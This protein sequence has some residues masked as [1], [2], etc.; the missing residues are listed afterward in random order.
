MK[1]LNIV[2]VAGTKGKGSTCAYVDSIL[3]QYRKSRGLPL[4]VGLFTSP[5]LIA[6]RERIRINS[7]PISRDLFAR[8][9][10]QVWD[11]LET[12]TTGSSA[13]PDKPVYFRYLTLLSYHVFLQEGV[14]AAIYETGVGGEYDS[15]NIVD[16]PVATGISALGIDHTF[17][18]GATV[19]KIAWHKAGIQ[20]QGVPSFTVN[21]PQ[22]AMDVV[23]ARAKERNVRSL[24]VVG[25]DPRLR[26]V[27][28]KPDADFQKANASLAIALAEVVIQNLD[29][30]FEVSGDVL[31]SEFVDGVEQVVWRGRCETK[32]EG[33]IVWYLDGAHTADSIHVASSW[34]WDECSKRQVFKSGWGSLADPQSPGNHV[35][36]FNQ[37]GQREAMGL[38]NGLFNPGSTPNPVHFDH[39]LFCPTTARTDI[40]AKKGMIS[41]TLPLLIMP[42]CLPRSADFVNHTYDHKAIAD[43]TLQK[44][45]AE[46]WRALDPSPNTKIEVLPT[47]EDAFDYVRRLD[48]GSQAEGNSKVHALITG[49]VHLV[50]R[51]LGALEGVDA[52]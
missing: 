23:S 38:L 50:G 14:D 4:K 52:V 51:A 27:R 3:C 29:P 33:N 10:F 11:A 36:I 7:A 40:G 31:P 46:K 49:S 43:L 32:V 21:Q 28:V 45:F 26:G 6:V 2:H 5:H 37:Q 48:T 42:W 25:L 17:T 34:Y 35:L 8:Y 24:R 44:A 18:L 41:E 13:P 12:A 9:F 47:I 19:D 20:K 30:R 39:V 15:T 1:K 22:A 16:S